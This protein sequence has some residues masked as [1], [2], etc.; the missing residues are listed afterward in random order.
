[1]NLRIY[2]WPRLLDEF[3]EALDAREFYKGHPRIQ[4]GGLKIFLDGV[5]SNRTAWLLDEYADAPGEFGYS[6][7]DPQ[8]F[9]EQV[10]RADAA[11]FQVI[12]HAVGD[13]AVREVL[14]VYERAAQING[15]RDS[16]HRIEHME[17]THP[18]DQ[19]RFAKLNVMASMTPLHVCNPDLDG[20]LISRVGEPRGSW[21]Y[22][23]RDLL[24]K[25]AHLSFGTDWFAINLQEPD[26]LKQIFAAVTRIPPMSPGRDPWHAEQTLSLV[27][28]IRCYTLEPAYAEFQEGCKGSISVGK[29]ADMCV[30]SKNIFE[31]EP[32]LILE[33]E[34]VMT[35]FDG[36]V[37][38][39]KG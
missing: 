4:S 1:L 34:V 17:V 3:D 32:S 8:E 11:D 13:R 2:H 26:P 27:Q 37:V 10:I 38:F 6:V 23:W 15:A 33:A 16:R 5:L 21:A 14:D 28:A 39:Q 22:P 29:F 25:G 30:L 18:N 31:G 19:E 35:V 24:R 9:K 36:R 12:S 20:Y 7:L